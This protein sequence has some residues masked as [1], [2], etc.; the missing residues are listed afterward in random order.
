MEPKFR[1]I[2][3]PLITAFT[4]DGE[5]DYGATEEVIEFMVRAGVHGFFVLGSTGMGP[6]MTTQQRIDTAEFVIKKI[7]RRRPVILHVGAADFQTTVQLARHGDGLGVDAIGI[8]PPFYFSDHTSWEVF[9]HYKGVAQAIKSPIFLYDNEKYS[10]FRFTPDSVKKLKEEIPSLCGMKASYYPQAMLL[11][12][13]NSL[14][15]DFSVFSGNTVDL[16]PA[17]PQG[18]CGAIP[19][20]TAHIPELIV[21][22]W[23]ALEAKKYD[24]AAALQKKADD[25]GRTIVRLGMRFGRTVHRD[26]FRLRGIKVKSYPRWPVEE[27]SDEATRTLE[28]ALEATGLRGR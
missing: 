8:V 24:E 27:L 21:A 23:N 19:P 28:A 10:G 1:G 20:P 18:L 6:V 16:F 25:Y 4:D 3:I 7:N 14:P 5:V 26:A 12:Y 2:Y 11:A 9:A 17:A 13:I 22:L 15:K